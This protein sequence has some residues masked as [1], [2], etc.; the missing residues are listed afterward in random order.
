MSLAL[1]QQQLRKRRFRRKWYR[2]W[3]RQAAV[4]ITL[5]EEQGRLQV[6]MIERASRVGDPW[7]GHMAFPGGMAEA[8]DRHS[9]ATALRETQEEIS[10][11]L[12][13]DAHLL[14]RLSDRSARSHRG[15]WPMVIAPYVFSVSHLPTLK[16]NHEV[17]D[18]VWVPLDFLAERSNRQRMRWRYRGVE[19]DLPCYFYRERRIW[20]LS[21][22]M[23]DELMALLQDA[24]GTARQ[25]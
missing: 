18:T 21:L 16:V 12:A 14:G 5:R 7:S 25:V 6:L 8:A 19:R 15:R 10:L 24:P 9:L 2:Y 11:D 3:A 22:M 1:V 17:A 23:L 4:A 13:Q 20:G